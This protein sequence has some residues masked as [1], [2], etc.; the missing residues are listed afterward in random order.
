MR[1]GRIG[2]MNFYS[3]IMYIY[4]R[5]RRDFLVEQPFRVVEW[6]FTIVEWPFTIVEWRFRNVEWHSTELKWHSVRDVRG[7]RKEERG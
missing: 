1:I 2:K 6:R 3:A 7:T 5:A 4:T